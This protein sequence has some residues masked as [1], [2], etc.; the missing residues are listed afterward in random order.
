MLFQTGLRE[1][2]LLPPNRH[3]KKCRPKDLRAAGKEFEGRDIRGYPQ[4]VRPATM[5]EQKC[6]LPHL[7]AWTVEGK[8]FKLLAADD[9]PISIAQ[10]NT[11]AL[12]FLNGVDAAG[13]AETN[14]DYESTGVP[15]HRLHAGQLCR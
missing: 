1:I 9:T 14:S 11:M 7:I 13:N 4:I 3:S 12:L 5:A 10:D 8:A 15:I 2:D 6:G